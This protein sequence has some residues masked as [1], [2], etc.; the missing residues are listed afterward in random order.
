M[1]IKMRLDT[2][3][4]TSRIENSVQIKEVMINED[5]FHPN[6]ETIALGFKNKDSSGVI[7]FKVE[8]LEHIMESVRK[9]LH[10][11]KGFKYL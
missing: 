8:E 6:E 9:K 11:I 10:L 2:S 4:G 3:G 7:E 1:N 5:F